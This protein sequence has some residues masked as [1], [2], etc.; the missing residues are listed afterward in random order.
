MQIG[1]VISAILYVGGNF[2]LS[3]QN[4]QL[5]LFKLNGQESGPVAEFFT[6]PAIPTVTAGIVSHMFYTS[7]ALLTKTLATANKD[8]IA[9]RQTPVKPPTLLQ[10]RKL[11]Y[12]VFLAVVASGISARRFSM[13]IELMT[14]LIYKLLSAYLTTI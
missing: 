12:L 6:V 5:I 8:S 10:T 11:L 2:E 14:I 3:T 7:N 1:R 13:L 4:E 9:K